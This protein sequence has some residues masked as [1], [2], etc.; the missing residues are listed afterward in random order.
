MQVS[1]EKEASKHV[2]LRHEA[3]W[4]WSATSLHAVI[5]YVGI[6]FFIGMIMIGMNRRPLIDVC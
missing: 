2:I 4:E 3:P 5:P 6:T 1:V